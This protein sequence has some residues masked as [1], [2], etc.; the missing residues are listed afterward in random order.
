MPA[1]PSILPRGNWAARVRSLAERL[2]QRQG[3]EREREKCGIGYRRVR[4]ESLRLPFGPACVRIRERQ[5]AIKPLTSLSPLCAYVYVYIYFRRDTHTHT[6]T[7]ES[8]FRILDSSIPPILALPS[9]SRTC[10]NTP[11]R[12]SLLVSQ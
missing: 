8:R 9:P 6:R 3:K 11:A 7:G 1:D 10:A 4:Y 5:D 2:L 12:S